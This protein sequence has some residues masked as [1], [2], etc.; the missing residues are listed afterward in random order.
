MNELEPG[1][2]D[3]SLSDPLVGSV[4]GRGYHIDS[5]LAAGGFGAI[6]R[7]THVGDDRAVALKV[8]HTGLASQ[9]DVVARF[10]REAQALG[11]L[12]DPH[13][14]RALEFG[15]TEDGTLYIVMELL[16]GESLAERFRASGPLAWRRML[17][18]ARQVCAA[19]AEAHALGIVH[20]DLKPTNIHLEQVGDDHDFVKV[21]DFGIAKILHGSTLDT[22]DITHAGQMVGT[23]DYMAPEQMFGGAVGPASDLFTLGVVMYEM[24]SGVRPFGHPDSP[25]AMLTTIANTVPRPLSAISDAP[26]AL[27][28][29][30][31]RC[32]ERERAKRYASAAELSANLARVLAAADTR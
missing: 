28:A 12:R 26:V 7:A 22:V 2:A 20:R 29:I 10:R 16:A 25:T 30:I 9:P 6:Y 31:A 27:D 14:V 19:L 1:R 5:R 4:L 11:A 3:G 21:L 24:I 15:E 13:T 32:I 23:F 17:G 8:L 18:I